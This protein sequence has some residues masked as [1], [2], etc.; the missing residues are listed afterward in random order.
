[1]PAY[2][3]V[4]K[5]FTDDFGL[6]ASDLNA[7]RDDTIRQVQKMLAALPAGGGGAGL[8][9]FDQDLT[10]GGSSTR[11]DASPGLYTFDAS[12]G[13]HTFDVA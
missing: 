9:T 12:T 11:F 6:A 3:R 7:S 1:M 2:S 4:N 10:G 5:L 13:A 8:F